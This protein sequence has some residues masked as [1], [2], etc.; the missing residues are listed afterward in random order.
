LLLENFL[1]PW[2]LHFDLTQYNQFKLYFPKYFLIVSKDL[3]AKP[4]LF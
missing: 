1:F 4:T 2:F 3:T